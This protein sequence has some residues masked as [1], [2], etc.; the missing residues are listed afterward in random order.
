MSLPIVGRWPNQKLKGGFGWDM[1]VGLKAGIWL[2]YQTIE[3]ASMLA[4]FDEEVYNGDNEKHK[5]CSQ[6]GACL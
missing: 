1:S 4:Q 3:S 5:H 6:D 2:T